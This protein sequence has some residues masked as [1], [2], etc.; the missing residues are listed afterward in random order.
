MVRYQLVKA[1]RNSDKMEIHDL[2]NAVMQRYRE[3]YPDWGI[4]YYA[5]ENKN[6]RQ[7]KKELLR[8]V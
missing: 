7:Y 2:L 3:L 4:I 6:R 1:I 8:V 5:I